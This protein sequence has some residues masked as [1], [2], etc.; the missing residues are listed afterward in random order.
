M[1]A[2]EA[3][4]YCLGFVSDHEEDGEYHSQTVFDCDG[5]KHWFSWKNN[6]PR[7]C[8]EYSDPFSEKLTPYR[9]S[10]TR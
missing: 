8:S 7:M 9:L 5:N 10:E 4:I 1:T 3:M 2:I 6:I